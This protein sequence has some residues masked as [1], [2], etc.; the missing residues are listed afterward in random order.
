MTVC[1][2]LAACS[3][4]RSNID[5]DPSYDFTKAKTYNWIPNPQIAQSNELFDKHFRKVM[6]EKMAAKGYSVN[7]TNPD[8]MIAYHG[9]V[10]SKVDVTNWGYRYPGWYGGVEVYQY[11]EGTLIVDFVDSGSKNLIYR[12]TIS[13][14][15]DRSSTD[16]EKRQKRINEAVDKI[17][18]SF[19]PTQK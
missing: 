19:P 18:K 4:M 8:F 9:D 13:A 11:D 5:Y 17:L 16:F 14:E 1:V 2:A 6:D 10:Q 15:M 7:E 12:A 3:T